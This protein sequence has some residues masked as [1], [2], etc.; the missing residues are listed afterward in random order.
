M[1]GVRAVVAH[2]GGPTAVLNASLAGLVDECRSSGQFTTLE[3]AR[4]GVHG[5]LA[6]DY[7]DLF[8][9]HAA[10]VEAV[11]QTPGS[12]IG[13]S[14]QKLEA[15]DYE[16]VLSELRR[17][18]VH[19]FFY[20][21]GNGSMGTALELERCA[22][23]SGYDLGITGIPKTIDNDL[24]VTDHTPGYAST[25]RFFAF[26]AR[27]VG[28]DN[29]SLPSPICVL[30]TL[31][32]GAGWIVAA[33]SF[34]RE[35]E[36]D[37]P[38]L[39]YFPERPVSL[40]RIAADAESVVRRLGRVTIAVCEGQLDES[41]QPF[42][43]DVDRPG[44]PHYRLASNLGHTLALLLAEKTRLRARAER[45]GLLGRSCGPFT[46][47]LDRA[48]AYECGRAAARATMNALSGNMVALRRESSDPYRSSTFLSP[49]ETVARK[50]RRLPLEWIA[51]EGNDV[52]PAF[53]TYARPLVGEVP[54]YPHLPE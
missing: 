50:Q 24:L 35:H 33:T 15:A 20:T 47:P 29:R 12:A 1:A 7:I 10:L 41:G 48:E 37:A 8:S 40:D 21:G 51:P 45:P 36:D 22:H 6:G 9:Q 43:A 3:G 31:G 49:L 13:S 32:R 2:G 27:D 39:I 17:R 44:V 5:L 16:R 53:R 18:D 42:G 38:H 54:G 46:S 30:E 23:A 11:A 26:A 4:F 52:L 28:E 19:W 14:R 34:A 25:A